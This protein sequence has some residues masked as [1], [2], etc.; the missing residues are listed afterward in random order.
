MH[1]ASCPP[2]SEWCSARTTGDSL[3][4]PPR[5]VGRSRN[6]AFAT[7]FNLAEN[8]AAPRAWARLLDAVESRSLRRAMLAWCG[9][10]MPAAARRLSAH[11]AWHPLLEAVHAA[12]VDLIAFFVAA[13]CPARAP[14][15]SPPIISWPDGLD[16]QD[17]L[18]IAV[19]PDAFARVLLA[20][21]PPAPQRA[22]LAAAAALLEGGARV[23]RAHALAAAHVA[24]LAGRPAPAAAAD[25]LS[26]AA[27]AA[28]ARALRAASPIAAAAA[29][30]QRAPLPQA[31]ACGWDYWDAERGVF[32][33]AARDAAAEAADALATAEGASALDAADASPPPPP[34]PAARLRRISRPVVDSQ[35]AAAASASASESDGGGGGARPAAGAL[36]PDAAPATCEEP[37]DAAMRS[38][39]PRDT[40][41]RSGDGDA[42]MRS[43]GAGEEDAP[44]AG[45]PVAAE[46]LDGGDGGGDDDDGGAPPSARVAI[47]NDSF[48][49]AEAEEE[50]EEGDAAAGGGGGDGGGG[51]GG[52]SR[53]DADADAESAFFSPSIAASAVDS[54]A[55]G[56]SAGAWA[57]PAEISETLQPLIFGAGIHAV[58]RV[59]AEKDDISYVLYVWRRLLSGRPVTTAAAGVAAGECERVV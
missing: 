2:A 56:A 21:A 29:A 42:T 7:W 9:A 14:G 11:A 37:R 41:A 48:A 51:G 36:S 35:D 45:E 12:D 39:E 54:S 40:A 23:A 26:D 5:Y 10:A 30:A 27:F 4:P 34:P 52:G 33:V 1:S 57:R 16:T 8:R 59:P 43:D 31:D 49:E 50:P 32:A 47:A 24:W 25:H 28:D 15:T 53:A 38:A 18:H 13:R 46:P 3:R 44:A 17:A 55:G 20:R 19:A 58:S 22:A 6:R